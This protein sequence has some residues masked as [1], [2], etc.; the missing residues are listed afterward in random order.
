MTE[1]AALL[2]SLDETAANSGRSQPKGIQ[3]ENKLAQARLGIA[4]SLFLALR[5]KHAPTAAHSMR[6]ALGCSTW[7]QALELASQERDQIET[8]ALLHD[9]GK[10]GVP[11]H[12]LQK[13]GNLTPD[14]AALMEHHHRLGLEILSGCC[15]AEVLEIVRYVPARYD[16][17]PQK[18][19]L[20]EKEIPFGARIIAIVDAF[21]AMTTDHVYRRAMSRER[22]L[23][24][25]YQHAGQQFDADLVKMFADLHELSQL[26]LQGKVSQS[27]LESLAPDLANQKW[28]LGTPS[29]QGTQLLAQTLFQQKLLDNMHDGVVFVDS[30]LR[31][32][33]WNQGAER[34]TGIA[35][36]AVYQRTWLP[37]LVKL[38]NERNEIVAQRNCPVAKALQTG[39]QSLQRMFIAGRNDVETPVDLHAIPV[40]G[41]DGTSYG[42]TLMLHD[43]SSETSL[44][45]KC[46]SLHS[47]ATQDP[48]TQVANRAEFDRVHA[49]FLQTHTESNLPCS[50]IICDIDHFKQVNDTYGHQAGDEAIKHFAKLLKSMSHHGDLVARYGGEEFVLL[51]ADC[52][53][54]V[55]LARA[56]QIRRALGE[57]PM[58]L[59]GNKRI[60]A[61]FGV[62]ENQPGDTPATM[63]RRADRALLEA[64]STGRN[65]TVQL[66]TGH[67]LAQERR[68]KGWW[69]FTQQAAPNALLTL[70]LATNVP[71]EIAIEKLR[72]F[73]ADHD[74]QI[75]RTD[76]DSIELAIESNWFTMLRRRNDRP[77]DLIV[78]LQFFQQPQAETTPEATSGAQ[79]TSTRVRATIRPKRHRDRRSEH[80]V[81]QARQLS[82]SLKSYLV[83]REIS[84]EEAS[85]L[86]QTKKALAPWLTQDP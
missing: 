74:A 17:R 51:C 55:A 36:M 60:T 64:K 81:Q 45:E 38:R 77:V 78:E 39:I 15:P 44:E 28:Q 69:P 6:V 86:S 80:A 30:Q 1:I 25:L 70:D 52:N 83:A 42:V 34:L 59:M 10:I 53:N 54:A 14:E 71:L 47:Q 85:A 12:I 35:G 50:L 33:L 9:I 24:E 58:P 20:I 29:G 4:S 11:D 23:A 63:L 8:A 84:P 72:G 7:T 26:D 32:F 57:L 16:G 3:K 82:Q 31:I 68:R 49:L 62:T 65:R 37:S 43:V 73:V 48:L 18:F 40:V 13:P 46:E 5:A 27:W 75:V 76:E 67:D 41:R 66:G 21:D 22:A 19:P 61:S 79:G 56:E 2:R